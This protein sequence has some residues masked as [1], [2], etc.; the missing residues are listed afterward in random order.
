MFDNVNRIGSDC[1]GAVMVKSR[2]MI[3]ASGYPGHILVPDSVQGATSVLLQ[4]CVDPD[5]LPSGTTMDDLSGKPLVTINEFD[6]TI[7]ADGF[8]TPGMKLVNFGS[9]L[10]DTPGNMNRAKIIPFNDDVPVYLMFN[11][12]K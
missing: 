8:A 2:D 6:E 5:N 4:V 9:Y 12:Y 10:I 7:V 1:L 11:F 3:E